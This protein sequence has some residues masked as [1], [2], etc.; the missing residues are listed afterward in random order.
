MMGSSPPG[1]PE[2]RLKTSHIHFL[3]ATMNTDNT[4][5]RKAAHIVPGYAPPQPATPQEWR[6][7]GNA[8]LQ[9]ARI[10]YGITVSAQTIAVGWTSGHLRVSEEQV[11]KTW[12]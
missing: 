5:H 7:I 11:E 6:D 12:G 8:L 9:E 3:E 1:G 2:L 10:H 4:R